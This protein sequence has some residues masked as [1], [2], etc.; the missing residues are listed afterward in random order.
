MHNPLK[1]LGAGWFAEEGKPDTYRYNCS[2]TVFLR[3]IR[4][5]KEDG[6]GWVCAR[7]ENDAGTNGMYFTSLKKLVEHLELS[8]PVHNTALS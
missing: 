7:F 4:V 5:P 2:P 6:G 8:R 1:K 3:A